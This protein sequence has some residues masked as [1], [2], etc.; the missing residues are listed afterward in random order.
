M[1]V[2]D[3]PPDIKYKVVCLR[4][5]FRYLVLEAH[6]VINFVIQSIEITLVILSVLKQVL[7]DLMSNG[8]KRMSTF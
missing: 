6:K 5:S 3:C 2:H 7:L 1:E 4:C 8:K